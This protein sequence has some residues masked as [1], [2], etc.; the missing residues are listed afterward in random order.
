[1]QNETF[2]GDC[3]TLFSSEPFQ[4]VV[5]FWHEIG[6]CHYIFS[7]NCSSVTITHLV[8][9]KNRLRQGW[10]WVANL[11]TKANNCRS[12][13]AIFVCYIPHCVFKSWHICKS[14]WQLQKPFSSTSYRTHCGKIPIFVKKIK[15]SK[16]PFLVGNF[17]FNVKNRFQQNWFFGQKLG[18][19]SHSV[20]DGIVIIGALL[21]SL[22][23]Y[24]SFWCLPTLLYAFIRSFSFMK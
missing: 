18:F 3:Q 9:L 15:L 1:M 6:F 21:A 7:D 14:W 19:F 24:I 2:W 8:L 13:L 11:V 12:T 5:K 23:Y 22:L 10:T 17:K 16:S 20:T 4:L